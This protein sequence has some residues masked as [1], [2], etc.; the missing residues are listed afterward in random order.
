[1]ADGGFDFDWI[2]IGSGFGGSVAAL[3]LAE[4]GWRV[5]VLEAGRRIDDE[6][7]AASTWQLSRFFWAPALGWT[8][9]SRISIFKDVFVASGVG[10]GGGSLVYAN[11][12]YRAQPAFFEHPQWRGLDDWARV[13]PPHY[14][15]AE[16]MLG[17][18]TVPW[19]SDG[20]QLLRR[21]ARHRGVADTFTRTPCG[22]FFGEPGATVPDPY[23]G[24]AGPER[25]GCTRCGSC[26]VGCR[27]GA[28][29]TLRKNY[30]W[31]AERAGATVFAETR[32]TDIR[33]LG[34]PGEDDGRA[35]YAV[36][37]RASLGGW[38]LPRR[39]LRARGVVVAAGALGTN[40]L[41]AHCRRAGGLPHLSARLGHGVRTN[42]ESILA[43]TLPDDRL[44]PARDVA[45]SASVHLSAD[46]HI[47][48]VSYGSEG[49]L[50][51]LFFT[52]LT[53]PGTRLT[54]P[55]KW[56]AGAATH[57]GE[58]LR[59]L[60]PR[61]WGRRTVILLVMQSLDNALRFVPR[62]GLLGGTRLGTS[63]DASHP[64]PTFIREGFESAAWLARHT[65]GLA[66]SMVTEALADIP[67]T[68]H[69]LGGAVIGRDA[70]CG[71]V[72]AQGRA[73]GYHQLLVCDGSILPANPGVN[74]S[75]TITALAEHLM[76]QVPPP[77]RA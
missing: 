7:F 24:G 69:L 22:V 52:R 71:V 42:S 3:R 18:Q 63:Q 75:L 62:R 59:S 34:G 73:F 20:Q 13:L 32:V 28:K 30:L 46:T 33:P 49:S 11:T 77:P 41:L 58:F 38:G 16:R 14:D 21:L 17:V 64:N 31:F 15:T 29:N 67:T 48:L 27:V 8:G 61:H 26:T 74:P 37:T 1:M 39:T 50:L 40:R 6:D 47:E 53:G 10:V 76:S 51:K 57:P 19:D 72:D 9:P 70:S 35:G 36:H 43:V 44:Q 54:R 12:L 60:W 56:L 5:A 23:F 55:L 4:K 45:I 65:G 68:A 66:Q 25:T 2:V